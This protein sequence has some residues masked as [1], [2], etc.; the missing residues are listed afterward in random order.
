M[1]RPRLEDAGAFLVRRLLSCATTLKA[2][3]GIW[4]L[5]SDD[6]C[7]GVSSII[8]FNNPRFASSSGDIPT[9]YKM[10]PHSASVL[11]CGFLTAAISKPEPIMRTVASMARNIQPSCLWKQWRMTTTVL[12]NKTGT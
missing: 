5:E 12:A 7:V 2:R 10:A 6:T 9:D 1:T 11:L 3:R 4:N 8:R